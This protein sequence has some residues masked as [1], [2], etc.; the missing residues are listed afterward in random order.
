MKHLYVSIILIISLSFSCSNSTAPDETSPLGDFLYGTYLYVFANWMPPAHPIIGVNLY[1]AEPTDLTFLTLNSN[2]SFSMRI[3]VYVEHKDT[4]FNIYQE[5]SYITMGT[6]YVEAANF[7]GAR[8]KGTLEFRVEGE[9]VWKAD[10]SISIVNVKVLGIRRINFIGIGQTRIELPDNG[11]FIIINR[12]D[13]KR[14]P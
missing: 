12:W 5:G 11:G 3:E 2:G 6:E 4:T 10:F 13:E 7:S 9:I 14:P 1:T 8:W